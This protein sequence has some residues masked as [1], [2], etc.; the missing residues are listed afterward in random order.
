V[1]AS[2]TNGTQYVVMVTVTNGTATSSAAFSNH[3]FVGRAPGTP[4]SV[5]ATPSKHGFVVSWH[6]STTPAGEPVLRYKV[7]STSG[8]H[9]V[10][11]TATTSSCPVPT[12]A[13][14][15]AYR[16]SVAAFDV[17]GWSQPAV[18]RVAAP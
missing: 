7:V 18:I 16:I 6:P 13:G 14:G 12:L 11:R 10:T 8:T 1:L 17:S 5:H 4:T 2:L 15:R 9:T 3:F